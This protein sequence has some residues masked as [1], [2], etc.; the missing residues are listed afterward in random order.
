MKIVKW[1][2]DPGLDGDVYANE[3][4]L[5]GNAL[6]SVNFLKIGQKVGKEI[7]AHINEDGIREGSEGNGEEMRKERHL[8]EDADKRKKWF[9]DAKHKEDWVWEEG[10][11]FQADF[12]NPYLDFNGVYFLHDVQSLSKSRISLCRRFDG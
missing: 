2:I 3:P 4:Y 5:Y 12:F 11:V 7:P 8:P 9:L 10:R 6:S 1:A